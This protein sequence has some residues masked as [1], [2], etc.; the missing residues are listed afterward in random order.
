[1][2]PQVMPSQPCRGVEAWQNDR[3]GGEAAWDAAFKR[4]TSD[5]GSAKSY[6]GFVLAVNS[7]EKR[8]QHQASMIE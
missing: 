3:C 1:M 7:M 2:L 6:F 4:W 8:T 5:G